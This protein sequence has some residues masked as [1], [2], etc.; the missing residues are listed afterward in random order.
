MR[1]EHRIPTDIQDARERFEFYLLTLK[2][3]ADGVIALNVED[4]RKHIPEP[5][6]TLRE[7]GR[8]AG[9]YFMFDVD[10]IGYKE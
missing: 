9:Y 5:R 10:V 6:S 7:W 4:V 8:Q 3:D 1:G 2:P